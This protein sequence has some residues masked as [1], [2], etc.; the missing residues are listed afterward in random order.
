MKFNLN[1]E[2][3][4]KP[5]ERG[6][7]ILR[8]DTRQLEGEDLEDVINTLYHYDGE[9]MSTTLWD[10]A[11]TF[12]KYFSQIYTGQELPCDMNIEINNRK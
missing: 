9:Y 3:K 2:I 10:F 1:D 5:T 6:L 8:Q 7:E 4:F 12:G 11:N